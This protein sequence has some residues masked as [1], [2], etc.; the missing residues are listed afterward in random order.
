MR[1]TREV[2]IERLASALDRTVC[3]GI[4]TNR[5]YLASVLR[6]DAFRGGDFGTALVARH[7]HDATVP[8]WLEALAAAA[9]ALTGARPIGPHWLGWT[10]SGWS[11]C[12]LP[13]EVDGVPRRWRLCGARGDWRLECGD[14][15]HRL[16][17]LDDREP[18]LL[19][20]R[21]DG[22]DVAAVITKHGAQC[23]LQADGDAIEVHDG[24][25]S[26]AA[27]SRAEA[28][29]SVHAPMHGRL[30]HLPETGRVVA[31]GDV[32]AIIEAMKIEHPLAAPAAG[33]V[34]AV[35]ARVGDQIAARALLLEIDP[36]RART[37]QGQ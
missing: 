1:G 20:A 14:A 31:K 15:L 34:R 17:A 5:R 19:R 16:A 2:A 12:E 36:G 22:R 27:T 6:S 29:G 9:L 35:H 33:T 24:R 37:G 7:H 30:L 18:G 11:E 3:H 28:P 21:I 4:A 8:T 32:L 10:S 26:A 23:W 25:F 13:L